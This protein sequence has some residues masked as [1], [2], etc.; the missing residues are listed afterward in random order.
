MLVKDLRP[1]AAE[2]TKLATGFF[3]ELAAGFDPIV[4]RIAGEGELV[5]KLGKEIGPETDLLVG[6]FNRGLGSGRGRL[7]GSGFLRRLG[8]L[9]F[10]RCGG[11]AR[12]FLRRDCV[13][14]AVGRLRGG[15]VGRLI[16]N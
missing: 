10:R 16:V 4:V 9:F 7:F 15:I 14:F 13:R 1:R 5:P 6:R 8:L 2:R 11:S 12:F 3:D